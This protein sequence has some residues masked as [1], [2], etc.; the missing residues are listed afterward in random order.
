MLDKCLRYYVILMPSIISDHHGKDMMQASDQFLNSYIPIKTL[1]EIMELIQ[2]NSL[3]N[4]VNQMMDIRSNNSPSMKLS[5]LYAHISISF[6][7]CD[8]QHHHP[9]LT[10]A[11]RRISMTLTRMRLS[12]S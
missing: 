6:D 8:L 5:D 9:L 1:A 10:N 7:L 2:M 4:F 12:S 11:L 3:T